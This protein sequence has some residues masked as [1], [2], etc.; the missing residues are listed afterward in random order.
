MASKKLSD[1]SPERHHLWMVFV[2]LA[3]GLTFIFVLAFDMTVLKLDLSINRLGQVCFFA[4]RFIVTCGVLFGLL[5][6][7]RITKK[8]WIPYITVPGA[9]IGL[10]L[11][12]IY[13]FSLRNGADL[14]RSEVLDIAFL[15]Y[16]LWQVIR[17]HKTMG[18]LPAEGLHY[19]LHTRLLTGRWFAVIGWS[20]VISLAAVASSSNRPAWMLSLFGSAFALLTIILS[21]R[22]LGACAMADFHGR[23]RELCSSKARCIPGSF[24][25]AHEREV[26]PADTLSRVISMYA[27]WLISES[28]LYWLFPFFLVLCSCLTRAFGSLDDFTIYVLPI[29][30]IV[31]VFEMALL[32][33][34]AAS[35]A[36][37]HN[38][39]FWNMKQLEARFS[40]ALKGLPVGL[41]FASMSAYFLVVISECISNFLFYL[42]KSYKGPLEAYSPMSV[43][44]DYIYSVSHPASTP[45]RL[46]LLLTMV[47]PCIVSVAAVIEEYRNKTRLMPEST[48]DDDDEKSAFTSAVYDEI[49]TSVTLD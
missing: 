16:A 1:V 49:R 13:H 7:L 36:I 30:I 40:R 34:R 6:I 43:V 27:G 21:A 3:L 45:L 24:I 44:L 28:L 32:D 10:I 11:R 5:G 15:A 48:N 35:A 18:Y 47:Q 20:L 39:P 37:L 23:Q 8:A 14:K 9:I 31:L 46:Y 26:A 41:F 38:A 29:F 42:I 2:Y 4:S 33:E 17:I 25:E 19:G 12:K 22:I